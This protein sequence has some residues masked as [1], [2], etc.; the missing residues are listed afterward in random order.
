MTASPLAKKLQ[1][2]SDCRVLLLNAPEGHEGALAP[3]PE[4]ATLATAARGEFDVVLLFVRGSKDIERHAQ[5][6][7]KAVREGGILW[8]AYPKKTS[9]IDTDLTRDVGWRSVEAAGWG[10]VAVVAIDTT[11]SA[12]R[13][14]LDAAAA[15]A[16]AA[17]GAAMAAAKRAPRGEPRTI[18]APPDLAA[19]LAGDAAARALWDQLTYSHRKEHVG[20]IDEAKKAET[21]AR[22]VAKTVEALAAG[23]KDRNAKYRS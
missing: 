20:Y 10:G 23:E 17:R 11:W 15:E 4:G 12:L 6:A 2:K 14:K 5:K 22:R 18:E 1:I 7:M 16:S 13:F 8:I 3:L 21:R 9:G 19:A